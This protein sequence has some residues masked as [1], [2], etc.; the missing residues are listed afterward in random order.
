MKMERCYASIG[1]IIIIG[2]CKVMSVVLFDVMG[3]YLCP[4]F[5]GFITERLLVSLKFESSDKIPAPEF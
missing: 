5:I 2:L 1:F 4:E 3:K